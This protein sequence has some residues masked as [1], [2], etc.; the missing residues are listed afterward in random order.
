M[1]FPLS[2]AVIDTF[3]PQVGTCLGP[4]FFS[5]LCFKALFELLVLPSWEIHSRDTKMDF[6]TAPSR[7]AQSG[8]GFRL[9][10]GNSEGSTQPNRERPGG[11]FL[12][13][14][15]KVPQIKKMGE[16]KMRA[17]LARGSVS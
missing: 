16:A 12:K 15:E 13:D 17:F 4:S 5:A 14:E 6:N 2:N 1:G 9:L 10:C 8:G 7:G 3:C 11:A